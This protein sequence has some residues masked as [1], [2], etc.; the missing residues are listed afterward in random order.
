MW[1]RKRIPVETSY[2]P[3][4]SMVRA[5]RISVSA[6]LRCSLVFLTPA[7]HFAT[8]FANQ[9]A[10]PRRAERRSES[11][12]VRPIPQLD[13]RNLHILDRSGG[14]APESRDRAG[15]ERTPRALG[16]PA[17][18][19]N[20]RDSSSSATRGCQVPAAVSRGYSA[21]VRHSGRHTPDL[22]EPRAELREPPR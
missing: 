8:H 18:A 21:L 15:L 22:A 11:A 12:R 4:P 13:G 2:F 10:R 5:I 1:S 19:R 14:H 3:R 9:A 17:P 16:Q 6:V 20:W 7:P